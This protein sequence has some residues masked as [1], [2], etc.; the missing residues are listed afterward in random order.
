KDIKL[1]NDGVS[2]DLSDASPTLNELD[3]HAL[4]QH[5][6][7]LHMTL[8]SSQSSS[9]SEDAPVFDLDLSHSTLL[10]KRRRNMDDR[11]RAETMRIGTAS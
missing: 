11:R 6:A 1:Y 3:T 8:T 9:S 5:Q 10:N 2:L 4:P 7:G